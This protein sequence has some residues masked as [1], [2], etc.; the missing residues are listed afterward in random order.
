MSARA[1][2]PDK[3]TQQPFQAQKLVKDLLEQCGLVCEIIN[4]PSAEIQPDYVT[5]TKSEADTISASNLYIN[6][7]CL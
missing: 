7:L 2:M 3:K 4:S 5:S 1:L 6:I